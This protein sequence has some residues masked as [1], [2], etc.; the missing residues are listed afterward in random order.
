MG[1]GERFCG[2][3]AALVERQEIGVLAR[4]LGCHHHMGMIDAEIAED[5][6]VELIHPLT[7][8]FVRSSTVLTMI[9]TDLPR[10]DTSDTSRDVPLALQNAT[11]SARTGL[12]SFA[13]DIFSMYTFTTSNPSL[14]A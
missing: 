8:A 5:V 13:P 14:S 3:V 2:S 4:E 12:S 9:L 1:I 11:H 6:L 7:P 10:R